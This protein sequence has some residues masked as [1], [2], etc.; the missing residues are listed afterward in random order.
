[1]GA[2]ATFFRSYCSDPD[3]TYDVIQT[4]NIPYSKKKAAEQES[5]HAALCQN[6]SKN[7]TNVIVAVKV[8][9]SAKEAASACTLLTAHSYKYRG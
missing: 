2:C 5:A 6:I 7:Y 9:S 8:Y 4:Q 1:M 3:K